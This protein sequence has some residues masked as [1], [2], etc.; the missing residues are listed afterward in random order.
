MSDYQPAGQIKKG[1]VKF[2][3]IFALMLLTFVG[4]AVLSV[5]AA[6]K[7]NLLG[8]NAANETAP[9]APPLAEAKP[10]FDVLSPDTNPAIPNIGPDVG[11]V[12]DRVDDLEERLSRINA[13]AAAASG[14]A[15]RAEGML[16]AFAARRAI[17]SGANLG[18]IGQ[19]LSERFGAVQ[20]QAVAQILAAADRP[21]TLDQ[22]RAE[23]LSNGNAWT[24]PSGMT[25]WGKF[26]AEMSELFIL[27]H[28]STPSPAPS[29]RLERARQ[30][31]E[32][33]NITAALKEIRNLPGQTK[34]ANWISKA[35]SYV[36]ARDALDKIERAALSQ[37]TPAAPIAP[38]APSSQAPTAPAPSAN[39][40]PNSPIPPPALPFGGDETP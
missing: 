34:A 21:V 40:G 36:A 8:S 20:P 2:R 32:I 29:R 23:L 27:R 18:Y 16:I 33:G 19:Q 37:A 7:Y 10:A 13:E 3:Y 14:N 31:T 17:D 22:L 5:W 35:A 26:R 28:E 25:A 12:A 4:G 11:P 24:M 15:N 9:Y 6:N 30:Y 38:T 1:G 39:A